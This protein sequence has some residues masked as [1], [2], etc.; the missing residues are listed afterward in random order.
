VQVQPNGEPEEHTVRADKLDGSLDFDP[1]KNKWVKVLVKVNREMFKL[2]KEQH[3]L[4]TFAAESSKAGPKM[5]KQTH[6]SARCLAAIKRSK[7]ARPARLTPCCSHPIPQF[8][9]G[10]ACCTS[11]LAAH[12]M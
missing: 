1:S 4:Q 7:E 8:S 9:A 10:S 11:M 3:V 2:R 12:V 6:E 5:A